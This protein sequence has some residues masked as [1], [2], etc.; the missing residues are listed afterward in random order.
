MALSR[1]CREVIGGEAVPVGVV[2]PRSRPDTVD[3]SS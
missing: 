2:A 3:R 1:L